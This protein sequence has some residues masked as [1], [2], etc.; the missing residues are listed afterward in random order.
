MNSYK[1]NKKKISTFLIILLPIMLY[2]YFFVFFA[3]ATVKKEAFEFFVRH[4]YFIGLFYIALIF[5]TYLTIYILRI[6]TMKSK[7]VLV[8]NEDG[9]IYRFP[10]LKEVR[11]SKNN[12]KDI[13]VN[14]N[15]ICTVFTNSFEYKDNIIN[16]FFH[17]AQVYFNNYIKRNTIKINLN[18]IVLND[19]IYDNIIK[20]HKSYDS[21]VEIIKKYSDN[22]DTVK[23]DA[24][25]FNN[26]IMDLNNLK[27]FTQK[28]IAIIMKTKP[29]IINKIIKKNINAKK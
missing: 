7:N 6:L 16:I 28:E 29:H 25:I 19:E 8:F 23:N 15:N 12:I 4:G 1:I 9:V 20:L 14:N 5:T 24:S 18:F 13:Y 3:D 21:A 10:F 17:P 26:C 2:S 11:I 22:I 27:Q